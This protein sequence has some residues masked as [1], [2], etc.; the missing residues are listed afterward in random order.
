MWQIDDKWCYGICVYSARLVCFASLTDVSM[1]HIET[2]GVT[3][4]G[5]YSARLGVLPV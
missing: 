1:W 5:V 4:S 2:T 3:V